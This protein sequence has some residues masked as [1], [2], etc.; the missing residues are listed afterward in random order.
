M[1]KIQTVLYETPPAAL[2]RLLGALAASA[3]DFGGDVMLHVGDCSS[4]PLIAPDTLESWRQ[5]VG[6]QARVEAQYTWFGANLGF[7]K[8]H[9]RL[10]HAAPVA[11]RLLILNPDALP[12]FHLLTRL[13]RLADGHADFG[14]VD[15]RQAPIEHPKAFDPDTWETDWVSGACCLVDAAAFAAVGGFDELFFLYAEDVDLSWRLRAIG[16]RLYYCPETFVMHAKRLV[17]GSPAISKA[18]RY[19]GPLSLML[20]RAKY[21]YDS[22]NARSLALLRSHPTPENARMLADYERLRQQLVPVENQQ[23]AIARFASDG[24]LLDQRWTYPLASRPSTA[25]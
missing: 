16:R 20:L 14:A 3:R 13:T 6:S 15:A 21:G 1:I 10:W 25:P 5:G 7:G 18:E 24:G 23:A 19:H 2:D 12:A 17:D 4:R 22:L 8:G 9:N 11:D